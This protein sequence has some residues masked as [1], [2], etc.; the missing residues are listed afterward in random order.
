MGERN[1]R[2]LSLQEMGPL[3]IWARKKQK[4]FIIEINN[5]LRN[6][7][8]FEKAQN[9]CSELKEKV[10]DI[11]TKVYRSYMSSKKGNNCV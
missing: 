2:T 5:L 7:N 3:S 11:K 1:G 8:E 10:K 4:F 6:I 9:L